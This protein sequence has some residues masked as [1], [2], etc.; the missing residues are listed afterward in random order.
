MEKGFVKKNSDYIY[1][2]CGTGQ[3]LAAE[4]EQVFVFFKFVMKE[5]ACS[6]GKLHLALLSL[7]L[8]WRQSVDLEE[9]VLNYI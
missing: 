4:D 8:Q 9:T 1:R 3:K 7:F 2:S 5:G 6:K